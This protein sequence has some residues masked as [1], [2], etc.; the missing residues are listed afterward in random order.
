MEFMTGV[1]NSAGCLTLLS[2]RLLGATKCSGAGQG[3][4]AA[5][6]LEFKLTGSDKGIW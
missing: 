5:A 3:L 4:A 1:K 2:Q 6:A